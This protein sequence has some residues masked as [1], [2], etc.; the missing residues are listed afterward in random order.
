MFMI[1]VLHTFVG[2][3][4]IDNLLGT[5]VFDYFR[6][7][8]C[9]PAVDMFVLTSGYF[10]IRWKIRSLRS[11]VIQVYFFVFITYF[12]AYIFRLAL[13]SVS[14]YQMLWDA[15]NAL[16][17]GYW[18]ITAYLVLYLIAP[19]LNKYTEQIEKKSLW[20]VLLIYF[21]AMTYYALNGVKDSIGFNSVFLFIFLYLTGRYIRMFVD[22]KSLHTLHL[23]WIYLLL[24][25][26]VTG[27]AIVCKMF[28]NDGTCNYI[29]RG[30][31]YSNIFVV[32]QAVTGF[33]FFKSLKIKSR[34]INYIGASALA[35]YLL[36]MAPGLKLSYYGLAEKISNEPFVMQQVYTVILVSAAFVS[37]IVLDKIR[38][39]IFYK[40]SK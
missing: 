28:M 14:V 2:P 21:I 13:P 9:I 27:E 37:A 30:G 31:A 26:F 39:A 29:I 17:K 4:K 25:V 16:V 40:Y 24:T 38:L 20:M 19:V 3:E 18:F 35:V 11:L 8:F 5:T 36:H 15:F 1:L 33:L 34:F 7:S 6:N 32:G 23:L 12:A 10:S 22:E